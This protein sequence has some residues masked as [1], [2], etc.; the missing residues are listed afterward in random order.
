[1]YA[2]TDVH[3]YTRAHARVHTHT[4][5]HACTHILS[6]VSLLLQQGYLNLLL[7]LVNVI[8][9]KPKLTLK[10]CLHDE[11]NAH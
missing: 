11:N 6:L 3:R 10:A 2:C 7:I 5:T 8:N 4:H 9:V 1:M